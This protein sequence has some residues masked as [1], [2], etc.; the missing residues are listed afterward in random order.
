MELKADENWVTTNVE[1]FMLTPDDVSQD[2][3]DWLND[4]QINQYLESRFQAHNMDSTR[5]FVASVLNSSDSIFLGI[6][7]RVLGKHVGNIK[8][9]PI[10]REH[11]LGEIGIMIGDRGAWGRGIGAEA[12][13][14]IVAIAK[15]QLG[16]RK[17]TAGC[18]A[19]NAGSKRAFE[20]A[21]FFIECVRSDH[22]LV[23]GK[24]E[25]LALLAK[26]I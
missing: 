16:L 26:F 9:G 4:P 12:I 5:A 24:T 14:M 6:T 2:Y 3:V 11:G 25:D 21:G 17:I 10:N 13:R 18:Y 23:D 8:L 7:S 1:L 22:F 19:T 20:N 15:H